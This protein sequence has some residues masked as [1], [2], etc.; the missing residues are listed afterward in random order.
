M[1]VMLKNLEQNTHS[2]VTYFLQG[3]QKLSDI[4]KTV[5]CPGFFKS[6]VKWNAISF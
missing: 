6:V 2:L 5:N 4:F 3:I 1:K